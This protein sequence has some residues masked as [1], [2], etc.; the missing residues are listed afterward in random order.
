MDDLQILI[1]LVKGCIVKLLVIIDDDHPRQA[2]QIDNGLLDETMS[3]LLSDLG[4]GFHLYPFGEVVN[5]DDEELL[6]PGSQWEWAK[7][8]TLLGKWLG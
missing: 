8:V 4:E 6:L 1:K 3:F 7:V 2:K 5:G